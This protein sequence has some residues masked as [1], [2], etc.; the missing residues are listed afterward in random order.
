MV[1]GFACRT[2]F[3]NASGIWPDSRRPDLS[4]MV[5]DTITGTSMPRSSVISAIAYSA[6]LAFSVSKMV[7]T[8]SRSTPP[9]SMPLICSP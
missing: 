8:S 4:V 1:T 7:S 3:Q 5:P 6:A 9:S 2:E